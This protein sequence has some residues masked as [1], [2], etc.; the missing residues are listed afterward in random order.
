MTVMKAAVFTDKGRVEV[1]EIEKPTPKKGEIRIK[2]KSCAICTFEQRVYEGIIPV[3]FPFVGG[4]EVSGS[5]EAIGDNVD[6]DRWKIGQRVA[7]RLLG[8]CGECHYCRIGEEN[9]CE[10]SYDNDTSL[11]ILGP[12]GL[13]EYLVVPSTKV[14]EIADDIP[15]P[16]AALAEP[17]AC[18]THSVERAGIQI[19]NDVVVIGA[20]I[21]GMLHMLLAKK[22]ASRVIVCEV[23]EE[24]RALAKKLGADLVLDPTAGDIEEKIKSETNGRGAD[25]VFNTT[26]ISTVAE[27]ATRLVAKTGKVLFY[28]SIHPDEPIAMSPDHIHR[29]EITITGSVSPSIESFLKATKLLSAGIIDPA[30]LI[31]HEIPLSDIQ[32]AF[33]KAVLPETYRVVVNME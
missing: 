22:S 26:A 6:Q 7:L 29:S 5:I 28:S 16:I 4:H 3:G 24:R 23:D 10:S 13:S 8:N 12:G 25:V 1:Q 9:L 21:M 19:G 32:E 18:V 31:S 20:G 27:Q 2:I 11:S 30:Q 33:E 15:F 14:Y 17:L